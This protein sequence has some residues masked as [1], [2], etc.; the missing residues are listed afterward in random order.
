LNVPYYISDKGTITNN[1]IAGNSYISINCGSNL[2]FNPSKVKQILSRGTSYSINII[3]DSIA[4]I[5]YNR[6]IF[7]RSLGKSIENNPS[8]INLEDFLYL[9]K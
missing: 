6:N 9:I 5:H 8:K 4:E 7:F 1:I 3:D 2:E